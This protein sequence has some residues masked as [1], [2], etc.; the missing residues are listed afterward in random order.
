MIMKKTQDNN[1]AFASLY[2]RITRLTIA[3]I[4]FVALTHIGLNSSFHGH[5]ILQKQTHATAASL[6]N[7]FALSAA[8]YVADQ[9][10]ESLTRLVNNLSKDG[11]IQAAYVFDKSGLLLAKSDHSTLYAERIESPESLPGVTSLATPILQ[12]IM[13]DD[14]RVGFARITYSFPAS[15]REAHDYLHEVVK[16]IGLMLLLSVML[17]WVLARK[18][19]RWQFKR[20]LKKTSTDD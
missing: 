7:Q 2:Q 17:T 1:P 16:Q 12:D 5:E 4:C 18:I 11:Y 8:P 13:Y 9:D 3:A 15:N 19:K 6:V 10:I 14:M 20:Y